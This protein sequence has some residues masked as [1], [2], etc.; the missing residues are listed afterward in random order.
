MN[1]LLPLVALIVLS[2]QF[3]FGRN[4]P[5]INQDNIASGLQVYCSDEP[6]TLCTTDSRV[7]LPSNNQIF[8]GEDDSLSTSCHVHVKLEL[9]VE[10]DQDSLTYTVGYYPGDAAE[11]TLLQS[12][13]TIGTDSGSTIVLLNTAQSD[14]EAVRN[15]GLAYNSSCANSDGGFHRIVWTVSD[16]TGDTV[17]CDLLLRLEDCVAPVIAPVTLSS[18]VMPS[19][20]NV[21][22]WAQDY[23][24]LR[25]DDCSAEDQLLYSFR[26]DRHSPALEI[27]CQGMCTNGSPT[28][29][30]DVWLADAGTDLNCNDTIEW[31]ERNKDFT[32]VAIVI[33]D[34]NGTCSSSPTIV[35]GFVHTENYVPVPNVE[36]TIT[37]DSFE[38]IVYTDENGFYHLL[39]SSCLPSEIIVSCK[40]TDDPRNGVSTL[41]LIIIQKHLLGLE[42]LTSPYKLIAADVNN[43]QSVS[44]IDLVEIRKLILGLLIVF[45]NNDSWRFVPVNHEFDDP[46]NPWPFPETYEGIYNYSFDFIGI[47]VGDVNNT[48][49]VSSA[50]LARDK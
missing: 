15:T 36:V 18:V 38:Q 12:V 5:L 39:V 29:L 50:R 7:T 49:R 6:L 43:S 47:K 26:G 21:I 10:S 25:I 35:Q 44:A 37:Y 3:D 45:P 34:N 8:L 19:S 11:F 46:I 41:D 28:F 16:G 22:L 2:G 9:T 14:I 40:K 17:K 32:T 20:G 4:S 24:G 42:E 33:E 1:A 30:V 48:F 31:S 27:N 13:T 23:I